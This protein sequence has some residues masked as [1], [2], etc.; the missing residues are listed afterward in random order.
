MTI[1]YDKLMRYRIPEIEQ[2][3]TARDTM[4][5]ALG[6]GLGADPVDGNQLKFVYE[7]GIEAFPTMLAVICA[8]YLWLRDANIGMSGKSLQ[9][10]QSFILHGQIPA[11]G[12][13]VAQPEVVRVVDKGPGKGMLVLTERKIYNKATG[14]LICTASTTTFC[15]GDGGFGGPTKPLKA[16]HPIPQRAP[17]ITCDLAISSQAG[18]IYRLSGDY[19][20]LHAEPAAARKGGFERPILHGLCAFGMTGHAILRTCC[21]YEAGRLKGMEVRF[22]APV[23]PGEVMRTQIWKEEG[24]VSFRA[25]AP[26]RG[27]VV[28]IDNGCAS[29]A[30]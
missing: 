11:E 5:Y 24:G 25:L 6:I 29:L 16:P 20:P 26:D 2:T 7:K 18:L 10:G 15:R 21:G 9:G 17:D 28:V 23:Y 13:F 27:N 4:L 22:S 14:D 12:R 1:D 8:P 3:W 30:A 19:N